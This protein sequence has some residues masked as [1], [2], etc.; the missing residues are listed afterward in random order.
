MLR[1]LYASTWYCSVSRTGAP[2]WGKYLELTK[3]DPCFCFLFV[4]RLVSKFSTFGE[5]KCLFCFLVSQSCFRSSLGWIRSGRS[6]CIGYGCSRSRERKHSYWKLFHDF[7]AGQR[8]AR[9]LSCLERKPNELQ[10]TV[11][12]ALS[13]RGLALFFVHHGEGER[14][15]CAQKKPAHSRADTT[16]TVNETEC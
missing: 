11:L 10:L 14:V 16:P 8:W 5:L 3:E 13:L 4:A 2:L 15:A 12:S 9:L 6:K 1:P 7:P